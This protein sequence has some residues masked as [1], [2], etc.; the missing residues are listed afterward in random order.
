[1]SFERVGEINFTLAP[2]VKFLLPV[3]VP[4]SIN[5]QALLTIEALDDASAE[6]KAMALMNQL[7]TW[8]AFYLNT[9]VGSI[10]I[11]SIRKIGSSTTTRRYSQSAAYAIRINGQAD[12]QAIPNINT[13]FP[14]FKLLSSSNQS[15]LD[16]S[17]NWYLA[18]RNTADLMR[19]FWS[20]YAILQLFIGDR[21]P[22]D[23]YLRTLNPPIPLLFNDDKQKE[24]TI[25][26]CIRD[27]MSH[28]T[29]YRGQQLDIEVEIAANVNRMDDI[30][31]NLITSRI[32]DSI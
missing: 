27:S 8:I 4:E 25:I 3:E 1:M 22:I 30:A 15:I 9:P 24:Y 2:N 14:K 19:K 7:S 28:P 26:V 10:S 17:L 20:Y 29:R 21:T 11:L 5:H 18:A 13:N 31:R 16:M 12:A 6:N 32:N 23:K